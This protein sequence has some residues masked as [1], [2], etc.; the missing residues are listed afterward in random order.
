MIFISNY[1]ITMKS[2]K[3][4]R[5][6]MPLEF[7]N[8]SY[9]GNFSQHAGDVSLA[10]GAASVADVIWVNGTLTLRLVVGKRSK[11]SKKAKKGKK[12]AK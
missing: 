1:I 8:P 4:G 7:F 6:S 2:Q 11:K 10:R 12:K 3:G 9:R 5:V